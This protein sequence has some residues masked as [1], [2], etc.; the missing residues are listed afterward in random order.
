MGCKNPISAYVDHDMP[1]LPN[2]YGFPGSPKLPRNNASFSKL[3]LVTLAA[4]LEKAPIYFDRDCLRIIK[5]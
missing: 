1:S 3:A 5:W 2:I 4:K